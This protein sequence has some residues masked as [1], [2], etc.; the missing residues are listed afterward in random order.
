MT[1]LALLA[2][3]GNK[4]LESLKLDPHHMENVEEAFSAASHFGYDSFIILKDG[5]YQ[6]SVNILNPM[7]LI[8]LFIGG[9]LP[10]VFS[11]L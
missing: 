5:F 9:V 2:E 4:V 10:F 1:A 8:G 7:V 3:Y 6:L 11:A